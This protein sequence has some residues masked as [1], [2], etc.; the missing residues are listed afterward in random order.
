MRDFD[1][2]GKSYK[3]ALQLDPSQVDWWMEYVGL[4]RDQPK[5]A[6]QAVTSMLAA[7]ERV[8]KVPSQQATPRDDSLGPA[9]PDKRLKRY[10]EQPQKPRGEDG[11]ERDIRNS[12]NSRPSEPL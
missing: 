2:A 10:V 5:L 7:N 11:P 4:L 6:D 3:Q 8:A 1:A 9:S 12:V